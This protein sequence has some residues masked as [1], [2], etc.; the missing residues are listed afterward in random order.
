MDIEQLQEQYQKLYP[1]TKKLFGPY[2]RKQDSCKQITI[3]K[4]DGKITSKQY[5]KVLLEVKLGRCLGRDDTVDHIDGNST[6]DSID[7]LQLLDRA[8]NSAES[9]KRVKR[10]IG[11]CVYCNKEFELSRNQIK[12]RAGQAGPFCS[13][14]CKGTYGT[15]IQNG[16]TNALQ[17]TEY[18]VEYY[19]L[20]ELPQ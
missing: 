6:N 16:H 17:R 14:R 1:D 20:K 5:A 4:I 3:Q 12:G 9:V 13:R 2:D 19:T 8:A 18:E 7:N 15:D 10:I 11:N